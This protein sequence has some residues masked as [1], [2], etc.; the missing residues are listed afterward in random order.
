M[1]PYE[2]GHELEKIYGDNLKSVVLYG[3]AAGGN[4]SK[5]FSDFNVFC[6][7]ENISPSELAKSNNLV[8][9]WVKKGNPPLH[10]FD[11]SHIEKSLDVFPMEFLDIK[12]K[13]KVIFGADPLEGVIVDPKNL[14]LQCESELKGK[15]LHLR[16]FYAA[17]CHK[18]RRIARMMVDSFSTFL[19]VF[20][21]LLR[22]SNVAVPDDARAVIEKVS[23]I[24]NFNP[25]IFLEI[26]SIR[27]GDS[28]LPRGDGAI[29][30]F[31]RYLT[32]LEVVTTYV[33][34]I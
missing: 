23:Q 20:R 8:R 3:S 26:V 11:K 21:A 19:T 4:H 30:F 27:K 34:K 1:T 10:F 32:E 14:R 6:V 5:K 17:N 24:V 15:L 18:P 13:H 9:K 16:S 25:E 29:S 28:I 22:L 12:E 7:L 33:D 2:F 31:E